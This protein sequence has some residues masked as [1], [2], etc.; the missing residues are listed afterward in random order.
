M[1]Q[2]QMKLRQTCKQKRSAFWHDVFSHYQLPPTL[3]GDEAHRSDDPG[4]VIQSQNVR[5]G[6]VEHEGHQVKMARHLAFMYSFCCFGLLVG[7]LDL[8][9]VGQGLN[10]WHLFFK[11]LI[12]T[13][14]AAVDSD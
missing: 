10:I 4:T 5:L 13:R 2:V 11:F 9:T 12:I 3:E 8:Y 14:N 7:Q 1:T 6:T